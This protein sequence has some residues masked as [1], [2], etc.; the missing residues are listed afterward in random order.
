[1]GRHRL[2]IGRIRTYVAHEFM[3]AVGEL[4][5]IGRVGFLAEPVPLRSEHATPADFFE[6]SSQSSDSGEEVNEP[7][8]FRPVYLAAGVGDLA[9]LLN[10]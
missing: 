8:S 5:K 4:R 7:E 6:W 9:Q 1:M 2:G 10:L 3:I